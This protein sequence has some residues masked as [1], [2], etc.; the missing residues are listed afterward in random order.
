MGVKGGKTQNRPW[1]QGEVIITITTTTT[2]THTHTPQT[3]DMQGEARA[4][5]NVLLLS[6][7]PAASLLR[8]ICANPS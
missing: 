7:I 3:L 2:T 1:Q 4:H 6:P 5:A 8:M